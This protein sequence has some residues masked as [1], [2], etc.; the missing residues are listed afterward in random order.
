MLAERKVYGVCVDGDINKNSVIRGA[1]F[2][3]DGNGRIKL[4]A[5]FNCT[6]TDCS[7]RNLC[8]GRLRVTGYVEMDKVEVAPI[9][10]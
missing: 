3:W 10:G 1:H 9:K 6:S 5:V 4:G 8:S 2:I 7:G